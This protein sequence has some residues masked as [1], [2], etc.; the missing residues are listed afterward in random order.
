[1][2]SGKSIAENGEMAQAYLEN[3]R[4]NYASGNNKSALK[5]YEMAARLAREDLSNGNRR[6]LAE[7]YHGMGT[8]EVALGYHGDGVASLLGAYMVDPSY[9]ELKTTVRHLFET[10][11]DGIRQRIERYFPA[12]VLQ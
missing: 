11:N 2:F 9:E 12:D 10:H 1:M 3:G 6:V 4:R 5:D 8:T 7:A